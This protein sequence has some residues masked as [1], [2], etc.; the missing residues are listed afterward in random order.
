MTTTTT[1]TMQVL[2]DG[3]MQMQEGRSK[4]GKTEGVFTSFTVQF[5]AGSRPSKLSLDQN[6]GPVRYY[7]YY[8][9]QVG[10]GRG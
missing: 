5:A 9:V 4:G 10:M 3:I 2:I 8:D 6:N 7:D 1:T